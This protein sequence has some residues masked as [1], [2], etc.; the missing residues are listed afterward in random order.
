MANTLITLKTIAREALPRLVDNLVFP[1]IVY[2]D[3]A[4]DMPMALGDTIRVRKPSVM[5]AVEFDSATGVA[6]GDFNEECVEVTLNRIATV[7]RKAEAIE[8]ATNLDNLNRAFIEPAAV[9]LAEKINSD[10]LALYSDIPYVCGTAG[11]TPSGLA[12]FAAARKVLNTNKAPVSGRR[13]VWDVEA[14]A[15]FTQV[16]AI[17]HAEKSGSTQALREGSIG[18][19][20]G[21]DNYMSQAVK[22]H[23]SGTL[24]AGGTGA[25]I[26]IKNAVENA[27]SVT[28]GV[29]ASSGGT[30][31][32]T[33]VKG[34]ILA[35]GGKTAV[36]TE[37][38]SAAANEITVKV[39]PA[40]TAA[41]GVEVT[42]AAS[43]TANLA[44]HQNAFA[45]V[46]R[47]LVNPD[48]QGVESY[49]T[50]YGG[51]SLRV[52]R[53]YNQQY[54]QSTYSMDVLY[55]YKTVYPELAVRVMG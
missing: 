24:A 5:E 31:T 45:Y 41:A 43:H 4:A 25:K 38:A 42:L 49:V 1:A 18:R 20:F 36:V 50:S 26:T 33:L 27:S 34:D 22:S 11:T 8:T 15:A 13:A 16:D 55:G 37:N 6:Y 32:G 14:D 30:L 51:I 7:D 9:A 10:G 21:I 54:K 12:D 39:Y 52:T 47:P 46:S 19:I 2:Q 29:T 40:V 53:G 17:V 28:L 48:G 44:F 3:F 23:V 35:I